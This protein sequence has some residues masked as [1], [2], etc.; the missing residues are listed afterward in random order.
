MFDDPHSRG[1]GGPPHPDHPRRCQ[2]IRYCGLRCNRWAIKG[3]KYCQFHAGRHRHKQKFW[4]HHVSRFYKRQLTTSLQQ[5]LEEQLSLKPDE[6]FSLFE[7]LALVREVAAQH[8]KI[9]GAACEQGSQQA[10]MAAGELMAISLERVGNVC[11]MAAAL[12]EE[13]RSKYSIHDLNYVIEQIIRISYDCFKDDERCNQFAL[14]IREQLQLS[15]DE[16]TKKTADQYVSEMDQ[17]SMGE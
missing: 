13:Q 11:R 15:R 16:G 7:E 5:A 1:L 6:Q 14:M 9:Y 17:L 10:I 8:V 4:S 3:S 2:G 12:H